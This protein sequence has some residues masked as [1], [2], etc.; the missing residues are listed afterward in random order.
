MNTKDEAHVRRTKNKIK[1]TLVL[2]ALCFIS[3]IIVLFITKNL[4]LSSI[5]FV[6][7]IWGLAYVVSLL[8]KIDP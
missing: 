8:D 1:F 6:I 5:L 7:D 2:C 3:A 4:V